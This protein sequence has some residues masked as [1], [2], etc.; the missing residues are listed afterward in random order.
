[1]DTTALVVG[2]AAIGVLPLLLG[3]WLFSR[4]LQASTAARPA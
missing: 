4:G 2:T 3:L 1:V